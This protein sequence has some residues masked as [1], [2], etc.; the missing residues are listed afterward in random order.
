MRERN[1]PGPKE[2]VKKLWLCIGKS[3]IL[4]ARSA[5]LALGRSSGRWQGITADQQQVKEPTE[6]WFESRLGSWS[7][8]PSFGCL[9]SF[10][11]S[12]GAI[13]FNYRN[14]KNIII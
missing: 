2:K 9:L 14:N 5:A 7:V 13:P 10:L 6:Q 12:S 11:V 4:K 8:A 1:I 3:Y